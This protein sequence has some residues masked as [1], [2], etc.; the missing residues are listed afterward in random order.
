MVY[1]MN[2]YL[3][4]QFFLFFLFFTSTPLTLSLDFVPTMKDSYLRFWIQIRA[5]SH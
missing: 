4:F 2:V 1:K 3:E 5:E